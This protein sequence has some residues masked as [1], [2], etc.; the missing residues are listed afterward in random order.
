MGGRV[1]AGECC[2]EQQ[3][4]TGGCELRPRGGLLKSGVLGSSPSMVLT[5]CVNLGKAFWASL[6]FFISKMRF[7]PALKIR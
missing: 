4:E 1:H 2:T 6:S 3:E 7:P 5:H